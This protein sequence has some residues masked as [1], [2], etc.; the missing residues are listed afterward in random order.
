MT[1]NKILILLVAVLLLTNIA[2][3]VFML[4]RPCGK[5][6]MRRSREAAMT[7]FLQKDMG[8][9]PQQLQQYDSLGRQ[10]RESMGAM[11]DTMRNAKAQ[12]LKKL[13]AEGFTDSAMAQAA[14]LSAGKQQQMELLMLQHFKTIRNLCTPMQQAKFDTLY[15]K[16]WAPGRGMKKREAKK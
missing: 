10:H 14:T 1:K 6:N 16:V 15:Y 13:A 4:S 8:F 3:L 12:L 5:K 7:E 2:M 9:S 11:F